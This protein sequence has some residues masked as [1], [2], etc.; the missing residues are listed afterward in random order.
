ML[1]RRRALLPNNDHVVLGVVMTVWRLV[2]RLVLLVNLHRRVNVQVCALQRE[3]EPSHAG[4]LLELALLGSRPRRFGPQRALNLS[5]AGKQLVRFS[6]QRRAVK[7]THKV[8]LFRFESI[9]VELQLVYLLRRALPEKAISRCLLVFD[10]FVLTAHSQRIPPEEIGLTFVGPFSCDNRLLL[11]L[12][13][14][15]V[16]CVICVVSVIRVIRVVRVLRVLG[17]G[18]GLSKRQ[19][20]FGVLILFS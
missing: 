14:L 11:L 19:T 9:R 16:V 3:H 7:L 20:A 8:L 18:I 6:Q 4:D 13:I 17:L 15:P 2:D 1:D 12:R 10:F 5:A